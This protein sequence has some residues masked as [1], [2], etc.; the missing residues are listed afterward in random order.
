MIITDISWRK[1][2]QSGLG[3]A[4]NVD[5]SEAD[6]PWIARTSFYTQKRTINADGTKGPIEKV[7]G[8]CM[9]SIINYSRYIQPLPYLVKFEFSV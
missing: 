9:G 5:V 4:L 8:H 7:V 1:E 3:R 6:Y 2:I